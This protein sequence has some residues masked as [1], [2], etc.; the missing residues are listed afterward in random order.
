MLQREVESQQEILFVLKELL[1]SIK[2][3]NRRIDE[4]KIVMKNPKAPL[5]LIKDLKDR[6]LALRQSQFCFIH[7]IYD[8]RVRA[9]SSFA[10]EEKERIE[11][12][13]SIKDLYRDLKKL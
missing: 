1:T 12:I 10:P 7:S 11:N 2:E 6:I 8:I 5:D 4:I 9:I 13:F 3:I